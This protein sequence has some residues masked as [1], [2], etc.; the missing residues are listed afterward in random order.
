ME[1]IAVGVMSGTSLDGLDLALVKF[2]FDSRWKFELLDSRFILYTTCWSGKLKNAMM[3]PAS[4]LLILSNEFGDFI[5]EKV[6][7]FLQGRKVDLVAS[8]GHTVFH[9]PERKMTFQMGNGANI[10]AKTGLKV[11]NDFRT[12]DVALNGQ[13]APLVPVGD[14][15]LFSENQMC[16]NLGGF[17]NISVKD[18]KGGIIA[19]DVCP[20]N[21]VLNQLANELGL[22]YDKNGNIAASGEVNK[23]VLG[24]LNQ[25]SF[26]SEKPPK[27]LGKEWSDLN[28]ISIIQKSEDTIEN[29]I[30]TY[31]QHV[32]E[33]LSKVIKEN[34]G[35]VL[36]TGGGAYNATIISGLKKEFGDRIVVP[37][38]KIIDFKE[39]ILFAFLGI[40]RDLNE[41]NCLKSVTGAD[42][43]NIG[44]AIWQG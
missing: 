9:Q 12:L 10:A 29:K 35:S 42:I 34:D 22:P 21:I 41:N 27:S 25:L 3:L 40:L 31:T 11:I 37:D 39:A 23:E 5:G 20:V 6:T 44:G 7:E 13:G 18:G 14:L 19:Y 43:D 15:L 8:H 33:Q 17:A 24:L 1:K 4:E 36:V 26:Y 2:S 16:L 28:V 30:S 38:K 32:V